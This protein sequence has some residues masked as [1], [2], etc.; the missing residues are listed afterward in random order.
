MDQVRLTKYNRIVDYLQF[1]QQKITNCVKNK[2]VK[3]R[4][5]MELVKRSNT[6]I[7][8]F[9]PLIKFRIINFNIIHL[10]IYKTSN[11]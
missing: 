9:E 1:C 6:K 8:Y 10:Y 5:Q 2:L 11:I 4:I 3:I 7:I